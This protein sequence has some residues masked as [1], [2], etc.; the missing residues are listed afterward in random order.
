MNDTTTT[1]RPLETSTRRL[2]RSRDDRVIAGVAAGIANHYEIGVGWVRLGF[3]VTSFFGGFGVL[4]YL[5][6]WVGLPEEGEEHSLAASS[7][8]DLEGARSWLG[9][10]FIVLAAVIVLAGFE[11]VRPGLLWAAALV[12]V[13][14]LLYRGDLPDPIGRHSRPKDGAPLPDGTP[15][16]PAPPGIATPLSPD[17]TPPDTG[18]PLTAPHSGDGADGDSGVPAAGVAA[19]GGGVVDTVNLPSPPPPIGSDEIPPPPPPPPVPAPR[20]EAEPSRP[21]R[22]RSLLGRFT[23][24]TMLIVL[25]VMGLFHAADVIEPTARQYVAAAVVTVGLG[26]VVGT[27]WGRARTLIFFGI[28][29]LPLLAGASLVRVPLDGGFGDPVYRPAT[30]AD[31]ADEYRLVGGQL[32]LDLGDIDLD[33]GPVAV[34]LTNAFG[35]LEVIVPRD[36]GVT[37]TARVGAGDL[38]LP[39]VDANGVD[40]E[41]SLVLE[42]DGDLTLDIEVGFGEIRVVRTER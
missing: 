8:R 27:W 32:T 30:V 9:L 5:L 3:V 42:G 40:V 31:V 12:L 25:G 7:V 37:I 11:L 6:G 35:S 14:V 17:A 21:R 36:A 18:S 23:M 39:G 16:P 38:T 19:A 29:L 28:L 26:L 4:L 22:R 2:E 24:G 33:A 13:G 10:A 1:T 34:E 20:R 15:A 41:R